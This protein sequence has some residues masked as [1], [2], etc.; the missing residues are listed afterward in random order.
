MGPASR[1]RWLAL[2]A[3][4]VALTVALPLAALFGAAWVGG[5]RLQAVETSSMDPALPAGSLLVSQ[6]VDPS[7]VR[8]GMVVAFVHPDDRARV[9]SHRV[10]RVVE[11][12]EGLFFR[13][14]GD[15]NREVDGHLV[16]ASDVR[17]RVRWHVPDLG[18]AVR[19]L[20]W[21][22]GF[23]L[24][25]LVPVALLIAGE[26]RDLV[27]RRRGDEIV[28]RRRGRRVLVLRG[29]HATTAAA[30]LSSVDV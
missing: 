25:V 1:R 5:W 9:V 3:A 16:P 18:A 22:R 6:D 13:T 24:L 27:R 20:A 26:V 29:D 10:V 17:S 21:P 14:R 23:V 11:R 12:R 15:A 28:V 7:E 2:P 19:W 8:P 30:W 4:A